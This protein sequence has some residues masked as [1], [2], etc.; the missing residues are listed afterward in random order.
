MGDKK[1]HSRK[2]FEDYYLGLDIGTDS[3]GWCVTDKDYNVLK[4]NGKA[5]WGVRLFA[6]AA[7]AA[8]RRSFRTARRR[9]Q[10]R[11][12][13]VLLVEELLSEEVA[14]VDPLFFTRLKE[15]KFYLEDKDEKVRQP[16]CLFAD[17]NYT[18]VQ[19]H[20]DYRT[21]YHLRNA[22]MEHD[23]NY[24]I[25]LYYLAISNFMKHRGHF[26]FNGDISEVTLFEAVFDSLK[27]YLV[28]EFE[29]SL[30]TDDIEEVKNVLLDK[31]IGRADKKRKLIDLFDAK[32]SQIKS[33][34]LG[35]ICG[36][37]VSLDKLFDD[38][39][40]K[41]AGIDKISFYDGID[42]EKNDELLEVLSDRFEM[43]IRLKAV[44]DWSVLANILADSTSI[45]KAQIKVYEKHKKDL[46]DLKYVVKKYVPNEYDEIFKD[47][48]V[49]ENYTSYVA[50]VFEKG[51]TLTE[52][53]ITEQSDFCKYIKKKLEK[54]DA[55]D[56]VLARIKTE[57]KNYIF[58]PKQISKNN[59]V[60]PYQVHLQELKKIVD[61]MGIDYPLLKEKDTDGLSVCDKILKIFEFRIP[62][63]VGP[64]NDYHSENGGNS[65]VIRKESGRVLPWNFDS[66]VDIKASARAFMS[67]LT[68][69]CTYLL[70]ED[71]L[72]KDSLLYSKYMLL[73]ELNNIRINGDRLDVDVKQR[74][75]NEIF[76]TRSGKFSLKKLTDWLVKENIASREDKVSGID[77]VFQTTLKSYQDFYR[78]L[79]SRVETEPQFIDKLIE[80]ILIFGNDKRMLKELLTDEYSDRLS[81]EEIESISKLKYSGWGRFSS[82]LL[83]GIEDI[84]KETGE[85]KTIINFM[86]NGNENFMELMS[87]KHGFAEK[88]RQQNDEFKGNSAEIS[89]DLV[90]DSYASP[91]VK[92][93]IWQT[94]LIVKEIMKVKGKSPKRIFVEVA[95][96][97]EKNPKRKETRKERLLA[98]YKSIECERRNWYDEINKRK[99]WE[100]DDTKLYLYYT[101]L[102]RDMYSDEEIP[103]EELFTGKYSKEH[104]YPQSKTKD[105][106]I[107][108]NLV[109]VRTD[110]NNERQDKM[111]IPEKF[112]QPQLWTRLKKL[113]LISE[114][115]YKRLMRK[116]DF[117]DE[118]LTGFIARQLVETRQSTK[119][120]AQILE[121]T[122]PETKVVYS[123][124]INVS[125]FR[126]MDKKYKL[127]KTR[128]INDFHHAKDAYLSIVVGNVYY[129]KFTDNPKNFIA[130]KKEYNLKKLFDHDVTRNGEIAWKQGEEGTIATVRK[131][132]AKNNILFTRYATEN[133]GKLFEQPSKK[134][135]KNLTPLKLSDSR[136]N[137][138]KYGGYSGLGYQYFSVVE[139]E[140]N[141]K[142]KKAVRALVAVPEYLGDSHEAFIEYCERVLKF[143][144]PRVVYEKI[145]IDSFLKIDGYPVH[146]A[147]NKDLTRFVAKNAVQLCLNRESEAVIHNIEKVIKKKDENKDYKITS[148]DK[149]SEEEVISIY[150][151]LL[152]KLKNGIF[153]NMK[154]VSADKIEVARE[155]F[156]LLSIDDKCEV[157]R[158][159]LFV[160]K[161]DRKNANLA[162]IGIGG[163]I[164]EIRYNKNL[165]DYKSFKLVS[166]SVTGLFENEID[167]LK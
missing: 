135:S 125:D 35:A 45:S 34:I 136:M 13:R 84:D 73:N 22:L 76:K 80:N 24:D 64:L 67:N 12:N 44:Y 27:E 166:Q 100:F 68:N 75:Y 60:I 152:D 14:K 2:E 164:G 56:E 77:K 85:I 130:G 111:P 145:K 160:F 81:T 163:D 31:K 97:K 109:L 128:S 142:N 18:D 70:D 46:Q 79:G 133:R 112:R 5:M 119:I 19:Y 50:H 107:I 103:L 26:F 146:L 139:H 29:V 122:L 20:K 157:I 132:M 30:E 47:S 41:D 92:R 161:C 59:S 151:I 49:K 10:R 1:N 11:R 156:M 99:D 82:K 6:K 95:R 88:I 118:E 96:E 33:E 106:S 134:N 104:I 57:V 126:Y 74:I 43:M 165:S 93:G 123:K 105:D 42:D 91:A 155:K 90:Y 63:Y 21:I 16:Y 8:K 89:Y 167:L 15:S 124:A 149:I 94:L 25:R 162:V 7:T 61:N 54:V 40:L 28:N 38:E 158:Q 51:N 55:E 23:R 148:Y 120:V 87:S 98:P 129:T 17:Q 3:V 153:S 141:M 110:Y 127:V 117:S 137:V 4:F 9:L 37:N 143:N 116:E 86:W 101:Q 32:K 102:G 83:N 121:Q 159:L 52:K 131:Y 147:C 71:V 138:K 108:N 62:Y 72:P 114:E 65:W 115:K 39:S 53:R 154:G 144:S 113:N 150:D 69:K 78:I 36:L 140:K 48:G 66:K 58:M